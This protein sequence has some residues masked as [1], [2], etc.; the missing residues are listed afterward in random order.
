MAHYP[1]DSRLQPR[2]ERTI[3]GTSGL[4]HI[5]ATSTTNSIEKISFSA[6]KAS[7]YK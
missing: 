7:K 1:I 4:Y 6:D 5:I 3:V 2:P